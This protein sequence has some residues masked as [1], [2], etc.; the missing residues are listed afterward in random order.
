MYTYIIVYGLLFFCVVLCAYA[1]AGSGQQVARIPCCGRDAM[2][3][4]RTRVLVH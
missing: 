4:D 2:L 1:Y 3:R